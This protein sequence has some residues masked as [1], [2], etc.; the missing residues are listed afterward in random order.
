MQTTE[1]ARSSPDS[2][3]RT[4]RDPSA[5]HQE[6]LHRYAFPDLHAHIPNLGAESGKIAVR[7]AVTAAQVQH[8]VLVVTDPEIGKP[9]LDLSPTEYQKTGS[10]TPVHGMELA[11]ALELLGIQQIQATHLVK[12]VVLQDLVETLE[13]VEGDA[14]RP[15]GPL[16]GH[17]HGVDGPRPAAGP[18]AH[19]PLVQEQDL[20]NTL[21]GQMECGAQ[22][23]DSGA[24]DDYRL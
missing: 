10:R 16:S 7:L 4:P 3:V 24:D 2:R 11:G 15:A 6:V 23:G 9:L 19:P 18:V 12:V 1:S 8:A 14:S 21:V 22:S 17:H 13:D 20:P 5:F